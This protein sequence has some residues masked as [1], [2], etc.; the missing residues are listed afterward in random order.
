MERPCRDNQCTACLAGEGS[1][2][3][4]VPAYVLTY[5]VLD[6]RLTL[7]HLLS[8]NALVCAALRLVT[9]SSDDFTLKEEILF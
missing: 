5:R 1:S 7:S 8:S 4:R 9:S 3:Y 2:I 6:L